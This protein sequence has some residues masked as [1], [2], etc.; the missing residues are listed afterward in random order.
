MFKSTMHG[1]LVMSHPYQ[2]E[3][4]NVQATPPHLVRELDTYQ[5]LQLSLSFLASVYVSA[6]V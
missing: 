5:H 4:L 3:G 2:F 6:V 1:L